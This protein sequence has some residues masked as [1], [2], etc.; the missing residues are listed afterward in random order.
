MMMGIEV[1]RIYGVGVY[2][3]VVGGGGDGGAKLVL[4]MGMVL[5]DTLFMYKNKFFT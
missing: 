5:A 4:R 1:V 3:I 2:C